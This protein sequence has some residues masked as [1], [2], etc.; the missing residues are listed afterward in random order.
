MKVLFPWVVLLILL[1]LTAVACATAAPAATPLPTVT[2]Y[3]TTTLTP[4]PAIPWPRI[5]PKP[6]FSVELPMDWDVRYDSPNLLFIS[7]PAPWH[8]A[9][10]RV[11]SGTRKDLTI[12]AFVDSVLDVLRKDPGFE[13]DALE[14]VSN[15]IYRARYRY[16]QDS[17]YC[18][19]YEAYGLFI[20]R[21]ARNFIIT[22]AVCADS[23]E[24]YDDAFVE[25]VFDSIIYQRR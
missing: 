15:S 11:V 1:A 13:L 10:I 2:P 8:Q 18:G 19:D 22:L 16:S 20:A 5:S 3:P 21:P 23:T 17:S 12:E 24:Q 7:A 25:R 14:E 6:Y 9:F 4:T